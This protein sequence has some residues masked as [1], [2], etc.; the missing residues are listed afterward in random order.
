MARSLPFISAILRAGR[1][2]RPPSPLPPLQLFGA[3]LHRGPFLGREPLDFLSFAGSSLGSWIPPR[4]DVGSHAAIS[5]APRR[6]ARSRSSRLPRRRTASSCLAAR[7]SRS[8][9][10]ASASSARRDPRTR[11]SA[12]GSGT[13][14]RGAR[15]ARPRGTRPR[16]RRRR[17]GSG[18]CRRDGRPSP[19]RRCRRP[20]IRGSAPDPSRRRRRASAVRRRSARRGSRA[21]SGW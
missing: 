21:R 17:S 15:A 13:S 16:R 14:A 1:F 9:S 7:S 2:P 4:I 8:A 19:R 18:R 3:L 11:A 6:C 12:D 20:T 5:P 10:S